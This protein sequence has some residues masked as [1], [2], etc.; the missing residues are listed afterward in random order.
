MSTPT[1]PVAA[2]RKGATI[3]GP[4]GLLAEGINDMVSRRRL[5]GYL[6]RA[7]LRRTGSDTLFGNIWWILDPLLQMAVYTIV[8]TVVFARKQEAY[9]LFVFATILPWKWFNS[10]ISDTVASV[11]GNDK[12]IKQLK[13]P[14]IVLPVAAI[15]AG[16][17]QFLFGLIPLAG[18]LFIFYPGHLSWTLLLIPVVM[19]VQLFLN[20]ALGLLFAAIN[21]FFR[22]ISN[23]SRHILRLWFYLSPVLYGADTVTNLA[24]GHK[25]IGTV[26]QANPFYPVL[27]AY[28]DLIYYGQLPDWGSLVVVLGAG[29]IATVFAIIVFKRLEPSFAK[30]L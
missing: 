11:S 1:R 4:F 22:D 30:V 20:L 25:I 28:R 15:V 14:K 23:L 27:N 17:S 12:L 18:M 3:P 2:Y 7:D 5:I 8:V 10:A 19:V 21:V 9:P 24:G 13:F 29:L 26:L 6:A 16:V